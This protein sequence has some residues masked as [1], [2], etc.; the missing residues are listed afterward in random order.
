MPFLIQNQTQTPQ[1]QVQIQNMYAVMYCVV[2]GGQLVRSLTILFL[3]PEVHAHTKKKR[4]K[5]W[6]KYRIHVMVENPCQLNMR[7]YTG[8]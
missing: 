1:S 4:E 2:W 5:T 6:I 7:L 3:K 8:L